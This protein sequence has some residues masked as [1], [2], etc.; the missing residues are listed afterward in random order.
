MAD[1]FYDYA[2][3]FEFPCGF[4]Y[5]GRGENRVRVYLNNDRKFYSVIIGD[6]ELRHYY[7]TTIELP[8]CDDMKGVLEDTIKYGEWVREGLINGHIKPEW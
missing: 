3:K 7:T 8:I 1:W 4:T 2:I 6:V 5:V